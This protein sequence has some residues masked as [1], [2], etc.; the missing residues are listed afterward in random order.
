[1]P[2]P[3]KLIEVSIPLQEINEASAREKSIRHG[4]PSTLH[5]WWARR[6]LAAARA[7]LFCQLVDDP[8][9][10]VDELLADKLKRQRAQQEIEMEI[11]MVP[12]ASPKLEE[13]L[14]ERERERLHQIVR[15]LVVWENT[16]NEKILE[17]ARA[18]IR[19]SWAR[20]C[21]REGRPETTPMPPVLDPFAGGGAIPLEA[22]RLGMEAHASD[23]NPVAV[24]INKA[25]IEI[26]PKFAGRPPVNHDWQAKTREQK[27]ATTW[28]GAQGLAE[29]V[30][31]YGDWM[32]EQAMER[33]GHLYPPY[34]LTSELLAAR[35]DLVKAGYKA[36]DSLTVI[37]WLWARTV[38]SPNPALGGLPVPL[39]SSFWLSKKP[40]KEA[41][42]EPIVEHGAYR[43]EVRVGKPKDAKAVEAGTKS[44][45]GASFSCLVS[46]V[47]IDGNFVKSSGKSGKLGATLIA[48]VCEGNRGRVYLPSDPTQVKSATGAKPDWSPDQKLNHDPRNIW[49]PQYGL[50]TY[51]DLFTQR[52]LVALNTF[53]DLVGEVRERVLADAQ[54]AWKGTMT[55][56]SGSNPVQSPDQPSSV[57]SDRSLEA[58]GRGPAAYADAVAVYLGLGVSRL[59]DICN[60]LNRWE[61][62]KTQVRNL[63]SRQAIPMLWDFAEN[64]V[65]GNAAGDFGVSLPTIVKVL[66]RFSGSRSGTVSQLNASTRIVE[67]GTIISSDPP[68]Y[69]NIGYADLSDFFY[70]WLRRGLQPILPKLMGSILVPKT[71]ELIASPYRQGNKAKAEAFFLKG[72][73]QVIQR[74]TEGANE[75]FPTTIY[76]AFKQSEVEKD[77]ISSTGWATFL[78][79][80]MTAGFS[81]V[82]TWPVRTELAN[83]IG[84]KANMLASSIVLVCRQRPKSAETITRR[85]FIEILESELPGALR[86]L[87]HGNLSPVDLP[88]SAIG[89]GMAIFSRYAAVLKSDGT[90]MTVTEALQIINHELS[91]LLDGQVSDMD[92]WTRWACKWFAQRAFATGP[93]GDAETIANAVD[94][95]VDRVVQAGILESGHGKVRLLRPAE[96]PANWDP[97][98]DGHRTV[99]EIVHH[100]IRLQESASDEACAALLAQLPHSEVAE[101]RQLCYR[102]YTLCE[103]SKWSAEA[104]TYNQLIANWTEYADL[105]AKVATRRHTEVQGVFELD[106]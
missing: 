37:A 57:E 8:S 50:E 75:Y 69:D 34:V 27:A 97:A 17:K 23:L 65:F 49:T 20:T 53:S 101:A 92:P 103:Q 88:Q 77:G 28:S 29:D 45:R 80:V 67:P 19:K 87:Q 31:Y 74:W 44:G 56:T 21:R 68:Y 32:R 24:L 54:A 63:F 73:T 66:K 52:Q 3:K 76:Y 11:A 39:V 55:G 82:G 99:W 94:V 70:V 40:G 83:K 1:M 96:L 33:I 104:Q 102:L 48:V 35:P 9:G 100:L 38:P 64:N 13:V 12:H 16:T 71:E 6:P 22:Q 58:G 81:I 43:F 18:E 93:Y 60:S 90:P 95:A 26:P 91:A 25:M 14:V 2:H 106:R 41:W 86:E 4:H 72:M 5:L 105:A 42:I 84:Q 51:A 7:V 79:A 62:T 61:V 46:G 78:E 98:T 85:E 47:P 59:T 30:R 15:E 89:P 10:Y 36:G